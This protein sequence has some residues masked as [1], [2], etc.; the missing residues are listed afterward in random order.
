MTAPSHVSSEQLYFV[1]VVV[2]GLCLLLAV[3]VVLSKLI[4]THRRTATQARLAPLR[5]HLLAVASGEDTDG[6]A[7]ARLI[8][9]RDSR[10]ELDRALVGVLT[11][12]RGAPADALVDVLRERDAVTSTLH[13]SRASS[14]VRRARAFRTLGLLRDADLTTDLLRGLHDR[15]PEVRLV[16]ARAIGAVGPPAGPRAASAVLRA[17]RTQ[18]THP[19]VAAGT[20][21]DALVRLGIT[22][23]P[24]VRDG[25]TDDD[26]GVRLVAA[27]VAGRGLFISCA[28]QLTGLA[29]TDPDQL[30]RVAATDALGEAGRADDCPVLV[31]LTSSDEPAPV[32]RAAARALGRLGTPDAVAALEVLLGDA[33]RGLA[34]AAATA[35]GDSGPGRD[36]LTRA[37]ADPDRTAPAVRA[38]RVTLELLR[39]RRGTDR[40]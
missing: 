32:R 39:L 12:V 24:A 21:T 7:R 10:G 14:S 40:A 35:L 17:V 28:P 38:A 19:G 18:R 27:T 33:D 3:V 23:E 34:A 9:H 2:L 1:A 20:A 11:K 29:R 30:V 22:S 25:L 26:P 4:T 15:S 37:A 5:P 13:A 6:A 8:A 36:T 31:T 16:S